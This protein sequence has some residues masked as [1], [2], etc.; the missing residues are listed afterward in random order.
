MIY[1]GIDQSFSR[2]GVC[3]VDNNGK[4]ILSKTTPAHET[5]ADGVLQVTE[6]IIGFSN[7]IYRMYNTE[8]QQ[9]CVEEPAMSMHG[10]K[11]YQQLCCLF[12][13]LRYEFRAKT[14]N[15]R[16]WQSKIMGNRLRGINK[17]TKA[18][19]EE[20]LLRVYEVTGERFENPDIADAYCI[21]E[22]TRRLDLG[23]ISLSKKRSKPRRKSPPK[24]EQPHR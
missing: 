4:I 17:R 16:S 21:A 7:T 5:D 22:Y 20:Y 18:G 13:V 1:I 11:A 2:S 15:P 14:V 8:Q 3:A 10:S 24:T 12:G 19:A 9:F 23:L 6:D